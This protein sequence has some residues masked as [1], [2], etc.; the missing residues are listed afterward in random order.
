MYLFKQQKKKNNH[1][2]IRRR[3]PLKNHL[4]ALGVLCFSLFF[5]HTNSTYAEEHEY[6]PLIHNIYDIEIKPFIQDPS[7]FKDILLQKK[8][9]STYETKDFKALE[10]QW[11]QE[12]EDG[13]YT[14][15]PELLTKPS[16]I[17]ISRIEEMAK[18]L[19]STLYIVDTQG[20]IVSQ[21]HVTE[22]YWLTSTPLWEEAKKL[23]PQHN[24]IGQVR[25]DP[26]S[27]AFVVTALFPIQNQNEIIGYLFVD[28]DALELELIIEGLR[29]FGHNHKK[30]KIKKDKA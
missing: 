21:S 2:I 20:L 12:L 10:Q 16:A 28:F 25:Y 5:C 8:R 6:R 15:L 11:N 14:L 18:G 26:M 22:H 27:L 17:V 24:Y 19:I 1:R 13:F 29:T 30:T 9:F 23:K 3:F 4:K 7:I